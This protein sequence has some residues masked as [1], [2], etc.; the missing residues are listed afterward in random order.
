M[1]AGLTANMTLSQFNQQAGGILLN[2]Q[3]ALDQVNEMDVFLAAQG[4][5]GLNTLVGMA[6]ADATTLISAY[7]DAQK[8]RNIFYNSATLTNSYDFTTFI[9]QVIG[10]GVH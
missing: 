10:S 2:L 3:Q 5:A 1:A 4:T 6:S 8:L 7:T 9:K